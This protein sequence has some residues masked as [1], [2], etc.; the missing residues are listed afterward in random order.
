MKLLASDASPYARKVRV[1]LLETEQS[2]V[3]VVDTKTNPMGPALYDSRVISRFLNA[4][5]DGALYPDARLW[6]TLTLEAT[7]DAIM[8]AAI[9]IVYEQR[10]RPAEL[11]WP[12]WFDAQWG[13]VERALDALGARWMSHLHGPVDAGHIA[14]GCALGYL[15]LRHADR[16]WRAGRDVLAAW[17]KD[18]AARPAMLQTKPA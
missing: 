16:N 1:V 17:E 15:D 3:E 4:R 8:D 11:H 9:G 5:A 2:D 12:A 18:F 14:V 10:L 13:K 6:E 7:G